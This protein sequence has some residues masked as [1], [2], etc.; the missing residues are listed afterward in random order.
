MPNRIEDCKNSDMMDKNEVAR[1]AR[2]RTVPVAIALAALLGIVC[3]GCVQPHVPIFDWQESRLPAEIE[4]LVTD[5]PKYF[6]EPY[7]LILAADRSPCGKAYQET[8]WWREWQQVTDN[9][10][11]GFVFVTT[12]PDSAGLAWAAYLDS[13]SAPILVLPSCERYLSEIGVIRGALPLKVL[14]NSTGAIR[15]LWAPILDTTASNQL[16]F[17]VDSI[18]RSAATDNNNSAVTMNPQR[19]QYGYKRET[20]RGNEE[21]LGG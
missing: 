2:R 15:Y 3:T 11:C 9:A 1:T 20:K 13:A 7:T 12:R 6:T 17:V 10:G 16:M 4:Q 5:N 14:V 18:A 19:R 21:N 8:V